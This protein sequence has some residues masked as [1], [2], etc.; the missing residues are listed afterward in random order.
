MLMRSR[1][2]T[3]RVSRRTS[4]KIQYVLDQWVP[5]RIRDSKLFMYLPMKLV[6]KDVAN[7]FMTFKESVYDMTQKEFSQLYER[8]LHVQELQGETDLND[9]CR[10]E[11]LKLIKNSKVLEVGC[12]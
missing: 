2:G 9:A 12:G 8:T 7:E 3:L 1:T 5:P 10:K 6:L 4:V 11:I